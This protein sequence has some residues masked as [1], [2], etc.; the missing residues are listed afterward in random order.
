VSQQTIKA[1]LH[2]SE[3]LRCCHSVPVVLSKLFF[4]DKIP[5]LLLT[6][7]VSTREW[8]YL[9]N[10]NWMTAEGTQAKHS[11]RGS[12]VCMR[13]KRNLTSVSQIEGASVHS[14]WHTQSHKMR[15]SEQSMRDRTSKSL[16]SYQP[17]TGQYSQIGNFTD[18]W[19]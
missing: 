10:H 6:A 15:Q 13:I 9:S 7:S 12:D 18:I 14:G 19:L 17:I 3:A 8:R 11:L 5:H 1:S 4:P 2:A 16:V